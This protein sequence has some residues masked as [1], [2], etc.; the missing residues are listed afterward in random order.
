M[1]VYLLYAVQLVYKFNSLLCDALCVL[2]SGI[3]K[4]VPARGMAFTSM[5]TSPVK[6]FYY[7]YYWPQICT[8]CTLYYKCS[9]ICVFLLHASY[10]K[11]LLLVI[12]NHSFVC[13]QIVCVPDTYGLLK[14]FFL[15]PGYSMAVMWLC[16]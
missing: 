11:I 4:Y 5:Y 9:F 1:S 2:Y 16:L 3:Y 15:I 6:S 7:H 13:V 10:N 14:C 12:R 8:I